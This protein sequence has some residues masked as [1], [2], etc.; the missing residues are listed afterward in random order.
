[1]G[2]PSNYVEHEEEKKK[3]GLITESLTNTNI[4]CWRESEYRTSGIAKFN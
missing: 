1:M 2:L 4:V 3:G